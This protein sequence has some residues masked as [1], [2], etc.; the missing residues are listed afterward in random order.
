LLLAI[1]A[2]PKAIVISKRNVCAYNADISTSLSYDNE[3]RSYLYH[4]K[5]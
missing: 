4:R 3:K 2:Q 5:M 1:E